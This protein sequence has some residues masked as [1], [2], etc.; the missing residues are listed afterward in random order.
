MNRWKEFEWI[1]LFQICLFVSAASINI[2]C[3]HRIQT[4]HSLKQKPSALSLI[5]EEMKKAKIF[6]LI[7]SFA[8]LSPSSSP[9]P[10]SSP[11]F[12]AF[13]LELAGK[14]QWVPSPTTQRYLSCR[15]PRSKLQRKIPAPNEACRRSSSLAERRK[16]G[17]N[18][19]LLR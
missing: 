18:V 17:K 7:G 13:S 10:H 16:I 2:H 15:A 19:A 14:F 3:I 9:F 6:A 8:S 11:V 5:S 1:P 4:H 12:L